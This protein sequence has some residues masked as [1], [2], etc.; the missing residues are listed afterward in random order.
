M[1]PLGRSSL[2]QNRIIWIF[3]MGI[4]ALTFQVCLPLAFLILL[5][6]TVHFQTVQADQSLCALTTHCPDCQVYQVAQEDQLPCSAFQC[7]TCRKR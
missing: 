1:G 2:P 7:G 3:G 4:L 6:L 5:A